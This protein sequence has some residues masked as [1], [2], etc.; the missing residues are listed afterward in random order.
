MEEP[1]LMW[2]DQYDMNK[3]MENTNHN[4]WTLTK[5]V[6]H[7]VNKTA[8][9]IDVTIYGG[10]SNSSVQVKSVAPKAVIEVPSKPKAP[11]K[12][13][14]PNAPSPIIAGFLIVALVLGVV[15]FIRKKLR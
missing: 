2:V 9:K 7:S 1:T 10:N 12:P 14:N 11:E 8:G 13:I 4:L 3:F 5:H 15:F 6:A